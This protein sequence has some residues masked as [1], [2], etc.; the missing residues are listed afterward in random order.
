MV[1]SGIDTTEALVVAGQRANGG[2][3][4]W[5]VPYDFEGACDEA[6]EICLG[7]PY[8]NWQPDYLQIAESVLDG[9][10][11]AEFNWNG[12]DWGDINNSDTSAVGWFPG[13]GLSDRGVDLARSLHR[14]TRRWFDQ[15]VH[16][17]PQLPGR[18]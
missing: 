16:R 4:V 15:P 13:E 6:P 3:A 17:T 1:I 9:T 12:P 7:V 14:R 5:A 2:E 8:F 10:F 18:F 11:T